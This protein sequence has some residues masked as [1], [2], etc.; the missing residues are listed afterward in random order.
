[1]DNHTWTNDKMKDYRNSITEKDKRI[2]GVPETF[3]NISCV[4]ISYHL[5][6]HGSCILYAWECRCNGHP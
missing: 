3:H 6:Y 2:V 4:D 1:M 5:I